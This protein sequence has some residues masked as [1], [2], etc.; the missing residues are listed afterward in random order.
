VPAPAPEP[1]VV[2]APAPVP[3][4]VVVKPAPAPEPIKIV[5]DEAVL[6]FKN[7]KSQL[8]PEAVEAIKHVA[9]SIKAYS[10]D[11]T[12]V[13]SGHTSSVGSLAMNKALSKRRADAVAKILVDS[14]VKAS[15]VTTEGYGPEKPLADNATAAGQNKNRRVE[16]DVNLQGAKAEIRK[17]EVDLEE[18]AA[19]KP[20]P[21]AK[22]KAKAKKK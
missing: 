20:A 19:A 8:S 4:P 12:L 16:I 10:G 11:Y 15:A 7:G 17:H 6:H 5:L 22:A 3:E 21:K 18:G 13:V 2:P 9:T 1:V 14:G